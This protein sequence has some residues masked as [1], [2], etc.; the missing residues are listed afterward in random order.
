[1]V[2]G[3]GGVVVRVR[4]LEAET[5]VESSE[6]R[7]V[8]VDQGE[9]GCAPA[10]AGGGR[11]RDDGV[12]AP[13]QGDD[14]KEV[15]HEVEVRVKM[16]GGAEGAHRRCKWRRTEVAAARCERRGR[17]LWWVSG[18]G[19]KGFEREG[20]WPFIGCSLGRGGVSGS[21]SQEDRNRGPLWTCSGS[22]S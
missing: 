3:R 13:G 18:V 17:R 20:A 4:Q 15:R 22:V 7:D 9:L 6:V 14:V 2:R 19:F 10:P 1:M 21:R 11:A 16:L 8:G 12:G 5:L